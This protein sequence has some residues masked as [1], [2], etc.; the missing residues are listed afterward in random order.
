M[1]HR[2]FWRQ[3]PAL[4][5]LCSDWAGPEF[6]G[7]N[8]AAHTA[9]SKSFDELLR[10]AKVVLRLIPFG[11]DIAPADPAREPAP[12][13]GPE[14]APGGPRT[15]GAGAAM[16]TPAVVYVLGESHVLPLAW[17]AGR[18][19]GAGDPRA[20]WNWYLVSK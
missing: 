20:V 10:F 7:A 8:Q 9:L 15:P 19:H 4:V 11:G 2:S 12:G 5:A 3:T 18:P 1:L 13:P 17:C 16:P 6:G 14:P